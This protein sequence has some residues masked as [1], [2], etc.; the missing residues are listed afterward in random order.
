MILRAIASNC[1]A[2]PNPTKSVGFFFAHFLGTGVIQVG[3]ADKF[4]NSF[5]CQIFLF[6]GVMNCGQRGTGEVGE[7]IQDVVE[8]KILSDSMTKP[9]SLCSLMFTGQ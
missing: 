7:I 5:C 6:K 3:E 2:L 9:C 8:S 1:L 4:L